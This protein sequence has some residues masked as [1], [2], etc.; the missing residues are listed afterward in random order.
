MIH[1]RILSRWRNRFVKGSSALVFLPL[2]SGEMGN[3]GKAEST[4]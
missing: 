4:V 2:A 3:V 1:F